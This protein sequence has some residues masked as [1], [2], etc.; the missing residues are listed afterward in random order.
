MR[1]ERFRASILPRLAGREGMAHGAPRRE[2]MR[3]WDE[4]RRAVNGR[5]R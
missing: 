5:G 2:V 3:L 1:L 4:S